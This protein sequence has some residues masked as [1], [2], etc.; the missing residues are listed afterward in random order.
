MEIGSFE[1]RSAIWFLDT[2]LT[3]EGSK[4]TCV[5]LFGERLDEFVDH[6]LNVTGHSKRLIELRGKSQEVVRAMAPEPKYDF[7]IC[8]R[9]PPGHV[10]H[11]GHGAELGPAEAGRNYDHS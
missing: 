9:M 1:G 8:R 5:D 2:I 10:R 7:I 3:G 4:L 6:N 11:G